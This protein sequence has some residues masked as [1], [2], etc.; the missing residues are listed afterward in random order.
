[1]SI[2]AR[3]RWALTPAHTRL[4]QIN[5]V[6]AYERRNL[7]RT[8]K[9][10]ARYQPCFK[11]TQSLFI[12]V[13][14]AAGRSVVRGLY[15][16]RSVEH[17]SAQWYQSL[18]ADKYHRYFSFTIVRNPWDRLS[19]AYSYLRQDGA[20]TNLDDSAWGER[21]RSYA[22]LDEFVCTW[23]T[24]ST[25]MEHI[26][27]TPQHLFV[28]NDSDEL[29]LDFVGRFET[30]EEDYKHIA[31]H[32]KGAGPLPHLNKSRSAA[33]PALYSDASRKIVAEVYK[34]DIEIFGYEF[35][36]G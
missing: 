11:R 19:S 28:C 10:R 4:A 2:L 15:D 24:T 14:K 16:V 9:G 8:L 29:D 1:M 6:P 25:A 30:L 34:R 17:A 27:F 13:P 18:D 36:R 35:N 7:E 12:H 5:A 32:V 33:Y 3:L 22:S 23:L 31:M 21:M 20:A 26:L